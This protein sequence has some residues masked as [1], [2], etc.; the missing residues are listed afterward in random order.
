ME[1]CRGGR[2]ATWVG[3]RAWDA[4]LRSFQDSDCIQQSQ[5]SETPFRHGTPWS[6]CPRADTSALHLCTCGISPIEQH[7]QH[8]PFQSFPIRV[9]SIEEI[10]GPR[11]PDSSVWDATRPVSNSKIHLV[12]VWPAVD[13]STALTA[14][15]LTASNQKTNAVLTYHDSGAILVQY[16]H[17]FSDYFRLSERIYIVHLSSG[18]L[19][20]SS[21]P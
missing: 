2:R 12:R 16:L 18:I 14:R 4:R 13:I 8:Q 17:A 5:R 10:P 1:L 6:Y 7:P 20:T 11:A 19:G 3:D 15:L 9:S 21:G